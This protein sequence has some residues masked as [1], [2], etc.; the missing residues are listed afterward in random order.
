[1][2]FRVHA[3][4]LVSVNDVNAGFTS[5]RMLFSCNFGTQ[6]QQLLLQQTSLHLVSAAFATACTCSLWFEDNRE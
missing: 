3:L 1:M 2:W 4:H 6:S 5:R